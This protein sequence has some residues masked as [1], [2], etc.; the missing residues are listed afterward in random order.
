M[1]CAVCSLPAKTERGK[2]EAREVV[3]RPLAVP[4]STLKGIDPMA[5]HA[6]FDLPVNIRAK[7]AV[8][9]VSRSS[10]LVRE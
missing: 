7:P 4:P 2:Q 5:P 6:L 8:W 10:G 1:R 9:A 3:R